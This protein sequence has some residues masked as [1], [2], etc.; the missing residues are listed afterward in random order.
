MGYWQMMRRIILPQAFRTAV[1]PFGN[2]VINMVKNTTLLFVIA[3][4]E[5]FGTAVDIYSQNFR[6]FEVICVITVWY[7]CIASAYTVL[8]RIVER[9]LNRGR[10]AL[11]A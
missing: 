3:V 4:P 11:F 1:P 8:Q 2:E 9:Q 10:K 7:I 6:Y 5:I